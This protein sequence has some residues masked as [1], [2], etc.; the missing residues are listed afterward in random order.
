MMCT[1]LA[2]ELRALRPLALCIVGLHF[3]GTIFLLATEMP[4]DQKFE[5]VKWMAEDR[6]GWLVVVALFALMI[7]AGLLIQESEQGTLRF[8]DGLPVSRTRLFAAKLLAALTVLALVPILG[9]PEEALFDWLS[10]T[11]VDA[12]YPWVFAG[13]LFWLVMVA[14]AFLLAL[15]LALSFVRAWFALVVGLL[16]WGYLWLRQHGS[17]GV[18]L[19]DTAELLAFGMDG[20]RVLVPW[21]HVVAHL[22]A[23]FV[24][25]GI[26]W[27][28]FLSLG[29]RAQFTAQKLGKYRVMRGLGVGLRWL[30]PVVWIAAML[31]IFG[32]FAE[33]HVD[34]AVT[35]VGEKAFARHE[36]TRYEFLYRKAQQEQTAPL[37]G[38]ADEVHDAVAEFFEAPPS[39][40]R[41]VVDLASPV[42]PH[43]AGQTNWTKIRMPLTPGQDLA[44]QRLILGHETAHV[45]I[46]Q[47]SDGRLASHFNAIRCLHEGLATHVE[48]QL[49]AAEEEHAQNRRSV[50]AAW[51][52]G[53]VPFEML[54]DNEKLGRARDPNL[55]YTLGEV[56][57][58]ELV[59]THSQASAANL[60]R[61]FARP[62]A[63]AG[64]IGTA[65]WRDT[66][67]AAEIDFDRVVAA[68]EGTCAKLAE[69][70][71]EFVERC[72]RLSAGVSVEGAEI[73]LRPKFEG[74]APGEMICLVEVAGPLLNE[75]P[76]LEQ[77]ADGSF[78]LARNR[79]SKPT[80]RYLLGWRTKET[81]LPVFEPWVEA[82]V[83]QASGR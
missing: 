45:F 20:G 76:A 18:A 71:Q 49:F 25:L 75:T 62:E 26:A 65:L 5:F 16:F 11:S 56:F 58:R 6:I 50:A 70:E 81:R 30:A 79:V 15:A 19:F 54:C 59:E 44:E 72:P 66:M 9:V 14:A 4:D 29:D 63:P 46:E 67:Q 69:E 39:P 3:L 40:A 74:T 28:G 10:R 12:P 34:F 8:L 2:K 68:Y 13:T 17:S 60:L 51:A 35:P 83:T 47:L 27:F 48:Q 22:S 36:T 21:G 38:V 80:L 41:I 32:S 24:L 82:V 53:R 52:R 37:L 42:V 31:R 33:N 1:L 7:G 57:V 64:L 61:A 77:R 55:A 23:T 78:T 73:V 43:A